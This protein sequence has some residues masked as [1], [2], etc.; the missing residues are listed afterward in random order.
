MRDSRPRNDGRRH[1]KVEIIRRCLMIG[2]SRWHWAEQHSKKWH[3]THSAPDPYKLNHL[4]KPLFSW[5]AVGPIPSNATLDPNKQIKLKDIPLQK[6]PLWLGVDRAIGA[7]GA[8]RKAKEANLM[9]SGLLVADAGTVLSLTKIT[10]NGEFDGGQLI[11]GLRLQ[12]GAM[13]QG[14]KDLNDPGLGTVTTNIFPFSTSEAMRRG[15]V[16]AIVG[17]LI[18]A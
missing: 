6:L 5:A 9:H 12:L 16:Q 7:W 18:D 1:L 8:Y 17:S 3:F 13:A 15:S 4:D 14:T 2:N 11:A 10:A